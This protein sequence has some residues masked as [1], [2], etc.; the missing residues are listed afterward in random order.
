MLLVKN[1]LRGHS[2]FLLDLSLYHNWRDVRSKFDRQT[3][4][5]LIGLIRGWANLLP[6][7][8]ATDLV[9]EVMLSD[10]WLVLYVHQ[11]LLERIFLQYL[12][13]LCRSLL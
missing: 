12:K 9:V 10:S 7:L 4:L 2:H 13:R 1:G 11:M 3:N 6:E 5:L 8:D